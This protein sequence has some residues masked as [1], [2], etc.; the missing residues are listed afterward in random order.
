[1][2]FKSP[3]YPCRLTYGRLFSKSTFIEVSSGTNGYFINV[4][5]SNCKVFCCRKVEFAL[6]DCGTLFYRL[7]TT[8]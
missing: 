3:I 8:G 5:W 2:D 6:I 7:L 4:L 1:M